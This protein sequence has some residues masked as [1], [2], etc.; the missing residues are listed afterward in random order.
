MYIQCVIATIIATIYIYAFWCMYVYSFRTHLLEYWFFQGACVWLPFIYISI[1]NIEHTICMYTM[2]RAIC[3]SRRMKQQTHLHT[4]TTANP[5]AIT[6][7]PISS[8][9]RTKDD[10]KTEQ[11]KI[12]W[13]NLC[14]TKKGRIQNQ[15]QTKS[16][17]YFSW[18]SKK[19]KHSIMSV[20]H[21]FE[22]RIFSFFFV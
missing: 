20:K 12:Y 11:E 19:K 8:K 16:F 4:Y 15:M 21:S 9:Y 10:E 22:F 6:F 1:A 14:R 7:I 17:F 13:Q 2:I 5:I 18:I 3:I